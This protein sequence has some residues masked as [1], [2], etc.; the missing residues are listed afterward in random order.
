VAGLTIDLQFPQIPKVLEAGFMREIFQDVLIR[1]QQQSSRKFCVEKCE[2]GEKRYKPGKSFVLSY[3]LRLQDLESKDSYDQLL[4]AQL[5]TLGSRQAAFGKYLENREYLPV[6]IPSVSYLSE[7]DMM[8]WAFPYDRKLVHLAKLL[9]IENLT[10]FVSKNLSG[11]KLSPSENIVSVKADVVHYLS[12]QSCML[13][14]TIA[15]SDKAVNH[16]NG[17]KEIIVYGKNYRD[18]SGLE[19]YEIMRQLTEQSHHCAFPLHYDADTNTLWQAQVPGVP[20][21]WSTKLSGNHDLVQK[22]AGCIASFHRCK[23]NS[24]RQYG[25]TQINEQLDSAVRIAAS[26][27]GSLGE[28]VQ[29]TVFD[30]FSIHSRINWSDSNFNSPLHL[31]LKMGNFLISNDKAFLIDMDCVSLGDSLSDTGSFVANLYLNGLRAGSAINE[32]DE[33]V[34]IFIKEYGVALGFTLDMTKLNWYIAAALIHEVL[35]RSLRQQSQERLKYLDD[36]IA[37]SRRYN[38][39]CLEGIEHV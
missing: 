26:W 25:F 1:N 5:C 22:I 37:L 15:I 9:D 39:L 12:G 30:L 20:F 16:K 11:L 6:G 28:R 4:T 32:I 14:Y 38:A 17:L 2:V 36:Y 27:D 3:K 7:V 35:R 23:I 29:E 13:R 18:N 8:L 24:N 19:T 21:E 33:V 34:S 31:D 10:S